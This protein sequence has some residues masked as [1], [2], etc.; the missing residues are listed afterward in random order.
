MRF[1]SRLLAALAAF[2][3]ACAPAH[4]VFELG[5]G[6]CET[7]TTT[8]TGTLNLAGA[9]TTG[10]ITYLSF[11]SQIT[12]TNTVPYTIEDSSGKFE[13]GQGVFTDAAPDTLTRVADWSSDGSGAELTLPAGTHI[14]CLQ[15]GEETLTGFVAALG[16]LTIDLGAADTTLA[17]SAAGEG[18]IEGDALKHAGKQTIWVPAG[19]MKSNTTNGCAAASNETGTNDLMYPTCNFDTST[20]EVVQFN[21]AMPKNW[22]EGTVTAIAYWSHPA[23][24][25]NFGV[26]WDVACV[27]LSNDDALDTA[28]G[29]AIEVGADT[30][31]TTDDLYVTAETGAITCAGTPAVD[32]DTFFRVRRVPA[33]AGDTLA[34]DA[35]LHGVKVF[36]TDDA[37]SDD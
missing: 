26:E 33:D 22:N 13:H 21:V 30:G 17:R 28:F 31:G 4:A 32:D 19:A 18:T 37:S 29:T 14:V 7:T 10:G 36:Y 11:A 3:I 34:V 6:I 15:T 23:T 16:P 1:Y 9:Y 24:T 35:R 20:Q 8:G 2:F 12:S 27:S 5:T 25:V